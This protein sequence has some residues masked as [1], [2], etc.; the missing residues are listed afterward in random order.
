M[1]SNVKLVGMGFNKLLEQ[2]RAKRA[3]LRNKL[4]FVIKALRDKD[5]LYILQAYNGLKQQAAILTGGIDPAVV[6][7]NQLIRRLMDKGFNWQCQAVNAL[8]D[9]LKSERQK[10]TKEQVIYKRIASRFMNKAHRDMG[11]SLHMLRLNSKEEL[12]KLRKTE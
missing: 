6:K 11:K 9:F 3:Q 2:Y 8:K 10:D 12:A 7:K 1:D 5:S 4:K